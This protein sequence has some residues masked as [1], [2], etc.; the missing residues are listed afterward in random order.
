[1]LTGFEKKCWI[2]N[3]DSYT[4]IFWSRSIQEGVNRQCQRLN[5]MHKQ[6][7]EFE[8]ERSGVGKELLIDVEP[9]MIKARNE[10]EEK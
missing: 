2:C 1:M 7:F 10:R 6:G 3:R 5:Y 9:I 4:L 8:L